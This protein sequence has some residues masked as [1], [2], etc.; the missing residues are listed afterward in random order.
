MLRDVPLLMPI[1][2]EGHNLIS[3][4]PS[5]QNT[6]REHDS[7][8][9]I[10]APEPEVAAPEEDPESDKARQLQTLFAK[11]AGDDLEVNCY[12]LQKILTVVFQ[13]GSHEV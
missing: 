7:R 3:R 8:P 6:L 9:E 4:I 2:A 1:T 5:F 12:E 10:I 13:K 11:I